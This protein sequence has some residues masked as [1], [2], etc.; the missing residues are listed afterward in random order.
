MSGKFT[1]KRHR[2]V[3]NYG[4]LDAG[5]HPNRQILRYCRYQIRSD[6]IL[7]GVLALHRHPISIFSVW[8][9]VDS[10]SSCLAFIFYFY[11]STIC[12]GFSFFPPS[13]RDYHYQI[14]NLPQSNRCPHYMAAAAPCWNSFALLEQGRRAKSA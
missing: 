8:Y 5:S 12:K 4:L 7:L 11:T 14:G 10:L 1:P 2:R 6:Q 9:A 3:E 13:F